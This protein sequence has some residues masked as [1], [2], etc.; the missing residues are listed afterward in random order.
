MSA[1]CFGGREEGA[2]GIASRDI[3]DGVDNMFVWRVLRSQL[4]S[5]YASTTVRVAHFE[6]T[7][8]L[9]R[10]EAARSLGSRFMQFVKI[11]G[12]NFE[13]MSK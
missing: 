2:G 7:I 13:S 5:F 3:Q 1:F 6:K 9:I 12:C 11:E 8:K 10:V 4:D